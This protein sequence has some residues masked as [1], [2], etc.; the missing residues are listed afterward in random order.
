MVEYFKGSY[1]IPTRP[2]QEWKEIA[3][4]HIDGITQ[5]VGIKE[6]GLC[7]T[8]VGQLV[9][10]LKAHPGLSLQIPTE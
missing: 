1:S 10:K 5:S 3:Q 7:P 8:L 2:E 9:E 6:E 4:S